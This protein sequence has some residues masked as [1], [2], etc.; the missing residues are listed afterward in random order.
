[1]RLKVMRRGE[2][3]SRTNLR[4]LFRLLLAVSL[5]FVGSVSQVH[6][7]EHVRH[8]LI[9]RSLGE[10]APPPV[11]HATDQCL[12]AHALDGT[13]VEPGVVFAPDG[14][15]SFAD[16]LTFVRRGE[17][18]SAAFQPRAPPLSA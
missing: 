10:G 2:H 6:A 13:A 4:T 7:L 11:N 5:A 15:S 1:M 17:S 12:L 3:G 16:D 8:D 14:V 18:P 9:E